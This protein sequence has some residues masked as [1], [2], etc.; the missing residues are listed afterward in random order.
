LRTQDSED[1]NEH[2]KRIDYCHDTHD[3]SSIEAGHKNAEGKAHSCGDNAGG[4]RPNRA[5]QDFRKPSVGNQ[6]V[7]LGFYKIKHLNGNGVKH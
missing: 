7:I 5:G 4:K 1:R 2:K 6:V 3:L